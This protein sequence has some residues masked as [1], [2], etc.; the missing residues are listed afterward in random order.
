M[1]DVILGLFAD[2]RYT[3]YVVVELFDSL[4][5]TRRDFVE[6]KKE[7]SD[8]MGESFLND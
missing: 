4:R 6:M 1:L 7:M 5:F 8:E 3:C 2:R